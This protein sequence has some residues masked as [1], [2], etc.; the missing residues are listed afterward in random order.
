[1]LTPF[2]RSSTYSQIHYPFYYSQSLHNNRSSN[3][4]VSLQI[5][6]SV[7]RILKTGMCKLM[8]AIKAVMKELCGGRGM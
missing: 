8:Y 7:M 2:L 3:L 4:Q 6:L 5:A 1:M